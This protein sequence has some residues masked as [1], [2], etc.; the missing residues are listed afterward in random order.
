M[1]AFAPLLLLML[2]FLCNCGVK[3]KPLPPVEPRTLG[4]GHPQIPQKAKPLTPTTD[5]DDEDKEEAL[6]KEVSKD[7]P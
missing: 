2:P 4:P 1:K 3:G 5:E 7:S 6:K